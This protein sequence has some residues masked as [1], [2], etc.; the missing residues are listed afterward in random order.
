MGVSRDP[1]AERLV[2]SKVFRCACGRKYRVEIGF[3]LD[4]ESPDEM[5]STIY[6]KRVQSIDRTR[7]KKSVRATQARKYRG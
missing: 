3:I 6:I 7:D 4:G 1:D 5:N 2:K